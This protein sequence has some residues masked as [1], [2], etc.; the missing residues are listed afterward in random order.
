MNVVRVKNLDEFNK[1]IFSGTKCVLFISDNCKYSISLE[2]FVFNELSNEFKNV[3][4]LI[5]DLLKCSQI[6]LENDIQ[7]WPTMLVFK[8]GIKVAMLE[9]ALKGSI[10]NLVMKYDEMN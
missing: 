3:M 5:V 4:F 9:G 6:G 8:H 2:K 1:Q 10:R 7:S